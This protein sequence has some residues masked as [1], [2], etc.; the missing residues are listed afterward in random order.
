MS[1]RYCASPD[2]IRTLQQDG[3]GWG[4]DLEC[5]TFYANDRPRAPLI[6]RMIGA[7]TLRKTAV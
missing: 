7:L 2:V 1:P 5:G 3:L 6:Q 4:H